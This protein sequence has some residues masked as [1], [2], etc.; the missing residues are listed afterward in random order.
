MEFTLYLD[1]LEQH[2][3]DHLP[4][5]QDARGSPVQD[6][7]SGLQIHLKTKRDV[8]TVKLSRTKHITLSLLTQPRPDT[9]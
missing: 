1:V 9:H 3:F 5:H 6:V 7:R 4:S 8:R 2:R